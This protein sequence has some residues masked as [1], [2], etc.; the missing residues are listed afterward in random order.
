M[1][2]KYFL[3]LLLHLLAVAGF[4]QEPVDTLVEYEYDTVYVPKDTVKETVEVITYKYKYAKPIRI[5][6][7]MGVGCQYGNVRFADTS[8]GEATVCIPVDI[9]LSKG[10]ILLQ[11]GFLHHGISRETTSG[12]SNM[13]ITPRE[14]SETVVVDTFYKYN[15]GNPILV[16]ITKQVTRRYNDTSYTDTLITNSYNFSYSEIPLALGYRLARKKWALQ[17][18]C[19]VS[20]CLFDKK[21]RNTTGYYS[22]GHKYYFFSYLADVSLAYRLS[23]TFSLETGASGTWAMGAKD[24][25]VSHKTGYV[26]LFYTIF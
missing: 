5:S 11:V 18:L 26:K 3:V 6:V 23:K 24:I 10:N 7:G 4:S 12:D 8:F 20:L 22:P 9:R 2:N 14:E 15:N 16:V 19:G 17:T 25:N 13:T 21:A 1:M